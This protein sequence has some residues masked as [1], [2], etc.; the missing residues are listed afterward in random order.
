MAFAWNEAASASTETAQLLASRLNLTA[1]HCW[2]G[3]L[4]LPGLK[5]FH[6]DV[7]AGSSEPHTLPRSA[8]IVLGTLFEPCEEG[9]QTPRRKQAFSIAET[10][11]ILSTGG[12]S[13]CTDYWGRYVAFAHDAAQRKTYVLRD[14]TG[15]LPCFHATYRDVDLYFSSADDCA[16]LGLLD[17]SIRWEFIARHLAFDNPC[18]HQTAIREISTVLAGERVAIQH[19]IATRSFAWNPLQIAQSDV[20]ENSNLAAL[21]LRR[22]AKACTHAWASCY[23]GVLHSLSGGL[24]SSIVLGCLQDADNRPTITC[25]NYHSGDGRDDERYFARLAANRAGCPLLEWERDNSV[26]LE[27]LQVAERTA[28]PSRL[29]NWLQVSRREARLAGEVCAGAIFSGC[30]G[31]ELFYRT[32]AI[33]GAADYLYSHGVNR[34]FVEVAL[35]TALL[36]NCSLWHVIREAF[37]HRRGKHRWHPRTHSL[38]GRKLVAPDARARAHEYEYED[39]THSLLAAPADTPPGK[40]WHAFSLAAAT[41]EYFDPHASAAHPE[42]VQPLLSQPLIELC[43][44]I[45]TYVL[46]SKG[47]DRAVA[48][49]AFS[50]DVPREIL[51]RR[52]KQGMQ[53]NMAAI[54]TRNIDTA[55]ELLLDGH[56]VGERLLD[57][58]GIETALADNAVPDNDTAREIFDH[59]S[60]EVWLRSWKSPVQHAAA[61]AA[62]QA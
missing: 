6:A 46:A 39:A 62:A 20:I 9:T 40:L 27:D 2:T 58:S 24:D 1:R 30:G 18:T 37:K 4:L 11:R 31:D 41:P 22:A 47:W 43:L 48:R 59:I 14:P 13:L 54:L 61:V 38:Y 50:D 28:A 21:E 57:R 33:L 35:D 7:R 12:G 23:R 51:R 26:R 36:E 15:G 49:Q 44:R 42:R 52:T 3:A 17:L 45:P 32:R 19:G 56:L 8:G 25:L 53:E 16:S 10:D 5:V 29:L 34:R 60:T 55:R